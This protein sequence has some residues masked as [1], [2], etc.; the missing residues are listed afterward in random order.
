MMSS[1]KW[2]VKAL[3]LAQEALAIATMTALAL[4][5]DLAATLSVDRWIGIKDPDMI[6][7]HL[8]PLA[9]SPS[10]VSDCQSSF[11]PYQEQCEEKRMYQLQDIPLLIN[12][13]YDVTNISS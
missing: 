10:L 13:F 7:A 2:M 11:P 5:Q 1:T 9:C 6:Q 3:D 8:F 12:E 4:A